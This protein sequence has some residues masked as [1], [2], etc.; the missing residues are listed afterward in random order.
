MQHENLPLQHYYFC[1]FFLGFLYMDVHNT[2]LI[3]DVQYLAPLM[4]YFSSKLHVD[5]KVLT[6]DDGIS[7]SLSVW[8]IIILLNPVGNYY[9]QLGSNRVWNS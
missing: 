6:Q 7:I 9:L 4:A 8:A 1:L 2:K 5:S 3:T